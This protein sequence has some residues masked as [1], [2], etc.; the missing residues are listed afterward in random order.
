MTACDFV[1]LH[2]ADRKEL[3][4]GEVIEALDRYAVHLKH[5]D[6]ESYTAAKPPYSVREKLQIIHLRV[7][8]MQHSQL[9]YRD[10]QLVIVQQILGVMNELAAK[11]GEPSLPYVRKEEP[12]TPSS[13]KPQ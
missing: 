10:E 8:D 11:I 9:D 13:S 12:S 5:Y 4:V 3:S 6:P 2:Y 7:K 1:F